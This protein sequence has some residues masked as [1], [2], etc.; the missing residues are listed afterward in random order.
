[1][2]FSQK[3]DAILLKLQNSASKFGVN[4]FL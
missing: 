3:I 2:P 4:L 1:V